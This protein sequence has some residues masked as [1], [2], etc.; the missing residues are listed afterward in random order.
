MDY[1]YA[2]ASLLFPMIQ[3]FAPDAILVSSGFDSAQGDPLGGIGVTPVGYAWLTHGLLKLCPNVLVFLEG[4]YNLEALAV[5]A[6]A[7][8]KALMIK[9]DND[10]AF[11]DL[12]KYLNSSHETYEALEAEALRAPRPSFKKL[13]YTIK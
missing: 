11:N 6:E 4:G 12:L 8:L 10:S 5:S 7:V 1:I 9:G 13:N 3:D 2:S